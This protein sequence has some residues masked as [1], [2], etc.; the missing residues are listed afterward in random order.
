MK[1]SKYV[2]L[3]L[4]I[5]FMSLNSHAHGGEDHDAPIKQKA[6]KGGIIKSL[7]NTLVEV[8]S[9]GQDVKIYLYDKALKP[10]SVEG[11][12]TSA[13][14]E[15]PRTKKQEQMTLTPK[16][17]FYEI[18]YDAKNLHRYTLILSIKDPSTGH[19][20]KLKFTIEPKK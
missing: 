18:I 10:K 16:D 14:A 20:D 2:I 7:E 15:I 8:V 19:D 6:P 4:L 11:F 12:L 5:M 17:N 1:F 9:R 13:V 3:P